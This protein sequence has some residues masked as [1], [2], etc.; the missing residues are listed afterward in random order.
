MFLSAL[1]IKLYQ[2]VCSSSS[3]SVMTSV[4]LKLQV[5][6]L[7]RQMTVQPLL[8]D[9]CRRLPAWKW[10]VW[11]WAGGPKMW[12]GGGGVGVEGWGWK[13]KRE[14]REAEVGWISGQAI[15]S[16]LCW[17]STP[18]WVCVGL[19]RKVWTISVCVCVC[20]CVC[21]CVCV[22]E[23]ERESLHVKRKLWKILCVWCVWKSVCVWERE[24]ERACKVTR[25]EGGKGGV[26]MLEFDGPRTL[27]GSAA[28]LR[29]PPPPRHLTTTL[30][31]LR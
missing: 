13:D 16:I 23:R 24:R 18:S 5:T 7:I 27:A 17:C 12:R 29:A 25:Q 3:K 6:H 26:Q 1:Y 15:F 2:A 20:V 21:E 10:Q 28:S 9:N 8:L 4:L 11:W 14:R 30:P 31:S 22:R 19:R